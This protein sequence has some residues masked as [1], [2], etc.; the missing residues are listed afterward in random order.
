MI[1]TKA[2]ALPRLRI[3]VLA[4]GFSTRLGQ[5]KA[6]CGVRGLTLLQRMIRV[7]GPFTADARIIV[8]VPPRAARYRVGLGAR[9]PMVAF[10]ANPQRATGLA[11]SVRAGLTRSR[12]SAGVLL[13]P[14][15]LVDLQRRDIERLIARWRGARR[16]VAANRI[17]DR[18]ATPLILPRW[19]YP[20]GLES[21]G[22]AGLRE[23]VRGLPQ[24]LLA[25]V[26]LRSAG[27]DVDTAADLER[28]R[29]RARP[30]GAAT[31]SRSAP[32]DSRW[33]SR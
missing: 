12:C 21:T 27:T 3:V 25:L 30:A 8:V 26:A 16:R 7:L 5:P 19:L 4:A 29:R 17:D 24:N 20:R 15:D 22:D 33:R 14:V 2:A 31:P 1:S 13:L 28:A 32:D 11:S 23:L 10:I 9:R 18:A 6:L